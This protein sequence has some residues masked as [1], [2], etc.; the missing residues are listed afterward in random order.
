MSYNKRTN[1]LFNAA[2]SSEKFVQ[3]EW[4]WQRT[5]PWV[6]EDLVWPIKY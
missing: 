6:Y 2:L 3:T 5:A 1:I 4:L